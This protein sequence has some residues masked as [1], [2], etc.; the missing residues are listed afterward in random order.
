[1]EQLLNNATSNS[2]ILWLNTEDIKILY[3][4]SFRYFKINIYYI[5]L[6]D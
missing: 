2:V 4:C 5:L 6:G 1:M 3:K